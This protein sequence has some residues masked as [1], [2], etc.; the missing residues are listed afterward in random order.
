MRADTR[1]R[2]G[3]SLTRFW[4]NYN[5]SIVLAALFLISW[6][7]QTWA[8]W[9]RFAANP[10]EHRQP[11]YSGAPVISSSGFRQRWKNWQSEFQQSPTFGGAH[12]FLNSPWK[13]RVAG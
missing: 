3:F 2:K 4:Q 12:G 8:G 11:R 13:S 6:A 1:G 9:V 7:L 10:E 5:L